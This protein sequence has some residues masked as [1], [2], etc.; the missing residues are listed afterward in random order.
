[1]ANILLIEPNYK[2]KYPPLGLMKIAYYH[3]EKRKDNDI[4]WFSKGE[5]PDVLS[6]RIVSQI[7]NS[8]YYKRRYKDNLD[9]HIEEINNII[10]NKNW[11]RVYVSTLF[12][13]EY[14]ETIKAIDYAKTLVG[15]ENVYT[16]GI[17]ATLMPEQ[18]EKDT[19]VKVNTGQLT[20]S[21]D[22][23]YDD[24]VNIDILTP[25][26][27][28]LDNTEYSYENEDAYYAYTTRGCGMNCGFCAVKTLEPEYKSFISIKEQIKN[29]NELYGKKKD[30]LLMDNN[31]LKS[32]DF[33]KIIGEII[34]LRFEKGATYFNEKTK[35]VNQ[36][37]VDFNQGLDAFLMTE[38]KA[39][40]LGTIALKPARIA[41][42]HI[43]DKK[44]YA[45]AITMA[46]TNGTKYL[47]NYLLYNA[48]SFS[49]KGRQYKADT[50]EDLYNR[51][52]LNVDLQE[53]LNES[54]NEENEKV[55]I[56][57]FP[58]RYIPLDDEQRGYVGSKWNKKYLRAVQSIL[59][60]TQGKGVSGK[61]F[62]EAAFGKTPEEFIQTIL[63]PESYIVSRGDPSKI[64]NISKE[65]LE[66][67]INTYNE[68]KLKRSEWER[69][70][71][72]IK[73]ET[74]N[75]FI[76]VIG[77]NKFDYFAF[78]QLTEDNEKKLF[79]H[80]L[81]D[82]GLMN[83]LEKIYL[84]NRSSDLDII[85]KYIKE[86]FTYKYR[87]LVGYMVGNNKMIPKLQMFKYIFEKDGEK[88]LLTTWIEQKCDS[89][90]DFMSYFSQ[91]Y[92]VPKQFMYI[93]KWGNSANLIK[94]DERGIIINNLC[95]DKFEN[96]IELFESLLNRIFD[97]I[98]KHYSNDEA[99]KTIDQIKEETAIQLGFLI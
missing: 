6:E 99:K 28:I 39:R 29:V 56:F 69:L 57:S 50:P 79:I 35:K 14:E 38:E 47:S 31:V 43:E 81:T 13:F 67:K 62:F 64:K 74:R 59:I 11:D 53:K 96:N 25:D 54:N 91:V 32:K 1:M 26:Y 34:E 10:K 3:K 88:D 40:L 22:I 15:K 12:T 4:V 83:I 17:L 76:N 87:D 58:M 85:I 45:K 78:K 2:C 82:P 30:L 63:M 7:K 49:G 46:A 73:G 60:P 84:D 93:L 48:E 90:A 89:N 23:G 70:Y 92:N 41:F 66:V 21:K 86:K 95:S 5:L 97:Y 98:K 75:K 16:G 68:F 18:L 9:N 72:S 80:Y 19:G 24:K 27:S 71:D 94:R 42:D 33:D 77:K 61:S 65:D 37:F 20:D 44:V 55:S 36:R 52:K 51:L 8:K